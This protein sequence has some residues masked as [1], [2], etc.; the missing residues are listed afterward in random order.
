MHLTPTRISTT[1]AVLF[2]AVAALC[3]AA[4]GP[5][6]E[7]PPKGPEALRVPE[8]AVETTV[9]QDSGGWA[10]FRAAL[11]RDPVTAAAALER[12]RAERGLPFDFFIRTDAPAALRQTVRANEDD[13]CGESATA[14]VDRVPLGH[15]LLA[16]SPAIELDSAGRV[17]RRWALS[18][19]VE[20]WDV[21]VGVHGDEL[22]TQYRDAPDGVYLRIR[23]DG[24]FHVSAAPPDTGSR[25]LACPASPELEGM[26]CG[27]FT[28]NGRERRIARPTICS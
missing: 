17:V 5:A 7:A 2:A 13:M 15:R 4:C 16:T 14:F 27:V 11:P 6:R 28:D 24:A 20:F 18:D 10:A 25:G 23:P 1:R 22:V 19:D 3:A 8:V 26:S 12:Y 21:V 9:V